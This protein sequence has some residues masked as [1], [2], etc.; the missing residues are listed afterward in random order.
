[1]R[2]RLIVLLLPLL[3]AGLALPAGAL[4]PEEVLERQEQALELDE[5]ERSARENGGSAQYG[6]GLDEGLA[7]LLDTGTRELAGVVRRAARSGPGASAPPPPPGLPL[8]SYDP[9]PRAAEV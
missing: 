3:L 9:A 2:T 6:A 7:D 5:L 1:M 4:T 8:P